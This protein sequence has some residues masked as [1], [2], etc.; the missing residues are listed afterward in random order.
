[1]FAAHSGGPI[2][3]P[4]GGWSPGN[5]FPSRGGK[6]SFF[7]GGIKVVGMLTWYKGL[8]ISLD[9]SPRIPQPHTTPLAPCGVLSLVPM[10]IWGADWCL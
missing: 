2:Q 10:L 3:E 7:E 9:H 8:D 1:M 6:Y 5:N 4:S